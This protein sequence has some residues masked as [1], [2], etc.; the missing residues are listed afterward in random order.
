MI[1]VFIGYDRREDQAYTVCRESIQR[2]ASGPVDVVRLDQQW[3]RRIGLYRRQTFLRGEQRYDTIDEKPY[4]TEFSFSR[5]LVPSLMPEGCALFCD[6][7]F[8]WRADVYELLEIA[9]PRCAVMTVKHDFVPSEVTKMRGQEQV[10]YPRKNWSSLM[11]WNC[12]HPAAHTLTP[13]LVNTMPGGWLHQLTWLEEGQIGMLPEEWNWLEGHSPKWLDPK[14]VHFTRG[15]PDMPG[16]ESVDYA[17][18]WLGY[19]DKAA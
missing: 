18:E 16:W 15:T 13:Y 8:L 17:D 3:L 5:F 1:R 6:S 7:D 14:A 19:V 2:H 4:S 11:L 12:S 10:A 9:D